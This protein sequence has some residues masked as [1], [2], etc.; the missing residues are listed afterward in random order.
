MCKN[1]LL[2]TDLNFFKSSFA[3]IITEWNNLDLLFRKS[4][5]FSV[6][7][8]NILKFIQPSSIS[9]YKGHNP[10]GSCLITILGLSLNLSH[11][12]ENKFKHSFQDTI[13]PLCS[14]RNDVESPQNIFSATVPNLLINLDNFTIFSFLT[15]KF[16]EQ[17]FKIMKNVS[18]DTIKQII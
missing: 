15:Q 16:D 5:S 11:L 14:C 4:E 7:K 9:V 2:N 12:R 13:N 6:F 18:R 1:L 17:L 10:R 3:S 8:T